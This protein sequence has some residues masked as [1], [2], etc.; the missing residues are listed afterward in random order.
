[1]PLCSP[2]R[3]LRWFALSLAVSWLAT[4]PARA[5]AAPTPTPAPTP[6]PVQPT[7]PAQ[8]AANSCNLEG[9]ATGPCSIGIQLG[10]RPLGGAFPFDVPVFLTGPAGTRVQRLTLHLFSARNPFR[11]TETCSDTSLPLEQCKPENHYVQCSG[12]TEIAVLTGEQAKWSF[13][14]LAGNA[15]NPAELSCSLQPRVS[16]WSRSAPTGDETFTLRVPSQ[17]ANRYFALFVEIE[18]TP[19]AE[20]VQALQEEISAAL[21]EAVGKALR[22]QGRDAASWAGQLHADICE[23]V[24]LAG[25]KRGVRFKV[26]DDSLL[27]CDPKIRSDALRSTAPEV[28]DSLGELFRNRADILE[29]LRTILRRNDLSQE[30]RDGLGFTLDDINDANFVL[31]PSLLTSSALNSLSTAT[32]NSKEVGYLKQSLEAYHKLQ[33]VTATLARRMV[34]LSGSNIGSFLTRQRSYLAADFGFI[35]A[36]RVGEALPYLGTNI[37]LFPV[38]KQAPLGWQDW[39]WKRYSATIGVTLGKF[40]KARTEPLFSDVNLVTGVGVRLTESL[41]L[42][43]GVVWFREADENPLSTSKRTVF[44]PYGSL[45]LD[46]DVNSLINWFSKLFR[47]P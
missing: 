41:R 28:F 39:G 7:T 1:M 13:A 36:E 6:A 4:L 17:P 23:A 16:T 37:Y 35:Y 12:Y 38:N 19:T 22:N 10:D 34:T 33:E 29:Q 2:I 24:E 47:I 20:Q 21:D 15:S 43:G 9:T 44:S 40:G 18:E 26:P 14:Q 32:G 42:G 25:R 30:T 5:Q 31:E 46:Y 27:S 45:S 11:L 3:A 8:G